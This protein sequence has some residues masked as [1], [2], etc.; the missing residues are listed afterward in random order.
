MRPLGSPEELERRR[1]QAVA[2]VKAGI[3]QTTVA[4]TFNVAKN[5]VWRWMEMDR[6]RKDGRRKKDA[7]SALPFP[8]RPRSMTPE[9]HRELK[10]LLLQGAKKHG[11]P[12]DLWTAPRVKSL[13]EKR[14][15]I[16][17]HVEHVRH[18]L[19]KR[20][21]FSSQRPEMRSRERDERAIRLWKKQELPRIKKKPA[22]SKPT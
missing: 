12:D 10:R 22:D 21:G 1:R 15:H 19:K 20:L 7:L 4:I 6:K 2:A 13:I 14:F 11:W 18:I 5:T 16:R 8:K 3:A 17:Y 9:Q